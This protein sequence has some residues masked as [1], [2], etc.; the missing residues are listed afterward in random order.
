MICIYDMQGTQIKRIDISERGHSHI[1]ING[2]ELKAGMYLYSL[3]ANGMEI[4]TKR[5]I[6]TK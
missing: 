5:M 1:I 2:S 6:L 3:F 4:D